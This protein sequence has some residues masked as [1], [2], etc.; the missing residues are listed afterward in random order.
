MKI[1]NYKSTEKY[2]DEA[3][4]FLSQDRSLE[5]I[6]E[7]HF[8]KAQMIEKLYNSGNEWDVKKHLCKR[9][10]LMA[11]YVF[12]IIEQQDKREELKKYCKEK[13]GWQITK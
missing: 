5:H 6:A 2:V 1:D 4:E 3:I 8:I 10:C 11:Y 12:D 9:E 7:L 13:L